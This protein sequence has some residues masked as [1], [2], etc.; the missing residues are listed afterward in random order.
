MI[1][2][3]DIARELRFLAKSLATLGIL[4]GALL[5][6]TLAVW[7]GV[8][9]VAEQRADIRA[10]LKADAA[11]RADAIAGQSDY[12]GA[13]YYTFHLTY[14]SPS[15][16]AFAALGSRDV[17]P[18][19]HRIRMLA[20]E[21]QIYETDAGNP[22]LAGAGRFDYAFV[23]A[24][25]APLL[26]VLLLY[27]VRAGER[28]AGRHD[29]LAATGGDQIWL[30]RT[31]ARCAALFIAIATPFM[32]GAAVSSTP[33][34]SV[35]IIL[36]LTALHIVLWSAIAYAIARMPITG[37]TAAT[38]LAGVWLTVSFIVPA[39]GELAIDQSIPSPEGGDIALQQREAVNDAWDLP[40]EATMTAFVARHPQWADAAR[41]E[42]PF[43]WKW[44]YAFQQVGDQTVEDL[45]RDYRSAIQRR[46]D[47][48]GGAAFASPP[49]FIMRAFTRLAETDAPAALAYE[50]RV[51]AFHGRLRAFYYPLLFT[52]ADYVPSLFQELPRYEDNDAKLATTTTHA[53]RN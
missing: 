51:R 9:E 7:T 32:I 42:Q 26:V 36:A 50:A 44:Y 2:L 4:C 12:G 33:I 25:L 20:L 3:D 28:A 53:T 29:L 14:D 21:G 43:E 22:A 45:S 46:Y 39:I 16:L 6:S 10:L 41:I 15:N 17:Y 8:N 35:F 48:A 5:L 38:T 13:A 18:W 11:E 37:P 23:V 49:I 1:G 47:A 27:D 34:S 30:A 52:D 24:L 40:K 19:K 31:S